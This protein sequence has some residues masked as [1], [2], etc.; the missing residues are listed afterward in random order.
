[1]Q[2]EATC[3]RLS[4]EGRLEQA[5]ACFQVV[6]RGTDLKS[7]VALYEAARL[8]GEGLHDPQRALALL[9]QY[10]KRFPSSALR[11]EVEWLRV[12][13][14][15]RTGQLEDALNASEELLSSPVG[16]PLASKLHLMRGHIYQRGRSDCAHAVR[17]YVALLGEPGKDGDDAEF[18]RAQ[19]LEQLGQPSEARVA[20]ERYLTRKDAH[21]AE[22]ATQRLNALSSASPAEGQAP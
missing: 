3:R 8:S 19:C 18:Q 13:N 1:M 12:R 14:L 22:L 5:V 21:D 15:E 4:S 7:E 6:G 2:D 16:R 11:G 9:E 20:Y 10:S 17:E